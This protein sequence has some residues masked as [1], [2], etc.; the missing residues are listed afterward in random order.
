MQ[1]SF[2]ST[3]KSA[4]F[5]T[6]PLAWRTALCSCTKQVGATPSLQKRKHGHEC[7]F[8]PR[9][10]INPDFLLGTGTHVRGHPVHACMIQSK[11]KTMAILPLMK[12]MVWGDGGCNYIIGL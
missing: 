4:C 3:G 2:F 12:V 6:E 7:T 8:R 11:G 5:K 10:G 9:G 1:Q